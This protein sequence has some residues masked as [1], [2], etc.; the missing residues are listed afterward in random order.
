M[1]HLY[2]SNNHRVTNALLN[3]D[4]VREQ[5]QQAAHLSLSDQKLITILLLFLFLIMISSVQILMVHTAPLR[6]TDPSVKEK[7]QIQRELKQMDKTM[8]KLS[9]DN[10]LP[11]DKWRLLFNIQKYVY[12]FQD[13][14]YVVNKENYTIYNS[15][16][17]ETQRNYC[18]EQPSQLRM[19]KLNIT[20]IYHLDFLL[21]LFRGS[22]S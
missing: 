3:T 10:V 21:F 5:Q 9:R 16:D 15:S 1:F 4:H 13:L 18:D 2:T 22:I 20:N 11:I 8:E 6:R 17:N 14:F 12:R 19:L 7:V